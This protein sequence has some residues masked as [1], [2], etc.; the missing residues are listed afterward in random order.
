[1][2]RNTMAEFSAMFVNDSPIEPQTVKGGQVNPIWE[3]WQGLFNT[4]LSQAQKALKISDGMYA[5]RIGSVITV[6]GSIGAGEKIEGVY[7]AQTFSAGD[8]LF[9]SEG[10]IRN[11]GEATSLSVT[12]I[13]GR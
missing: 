13:A 8:V 11:D 10:F 12:F 5:N 9:S 2:D 7:P 3:R 6:T 4:W 1:M